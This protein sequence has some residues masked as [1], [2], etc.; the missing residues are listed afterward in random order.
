MALVAL[1]NGVEGDG[2]LKNVIIEREVAAVV[3]MLIEVAMMSI[4]ANA[5]GDEVNAL[6]LD[7]LN[8]NFLLLSG[9]LE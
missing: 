5:P 6:G 2:V 8:A 9:D 3:H 7:A 4:C 1:G